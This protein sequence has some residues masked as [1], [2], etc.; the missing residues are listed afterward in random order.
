MVGGFSASWLMKGWA[1]QDLW[2]VSIAQLVPDHSLLRYYMCACSCVG[3]PETIGQSLKALSSWLR[4][5]K[6]D[7]AIDTLNLHQNVAVA[8]TVQ[9]LKGT[10]HFCDAV[11]VVG[12]NKLLSTFLFDCIADL[13]Q[14]RFVG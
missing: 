3:P 11:D 2:L 4:M 14:V 9:G 8:A 13:V 12:G 1:E 7:E 5:C 6:P 10:E